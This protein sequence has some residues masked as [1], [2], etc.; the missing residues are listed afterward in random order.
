MILFWQNHVIIFGADSLQLWGPFT[1]IAVISTRS[2]YNRLGK[3]VSRD[4]NWPWGQ[5]LVNEQIRWQIQME[6]EY[7]CWCPCNA[8]FN[9]CLQ[10]YWCSQR[11]EYIYFEK[12][13]C[14]VL[15]TFFPMSNNVNVFGC[16]T[17]Q[18]CI[19][20]CGMAYVKRWVCFWLPVFRL[21]ASIITSPPLPH[22]R[23]LLCYR[24]RSFCC[25]SCLNVIVSLT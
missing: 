11:L 24:C 3:S 12:T 5:V 20:F 16:G 18:Q 22:L 15:S 8:A 1:L 2:Q 13:A 23:P 19:I 25:I 7:L 14:Q 4:I 17:D 9:A 21:I 6:W 10:M